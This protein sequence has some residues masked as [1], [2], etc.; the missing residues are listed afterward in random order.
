MTLNKSIKFI[1]A[2]AV[3]IGT[4]S[5]A[6]HAAAFKPAEVKL[7]DSG[8]RMI[9]TMDVKQGYNDNV[10]GTDD[11][12]VDSESSAVLEIDPSLSFVINRQDSTYN[13]DLNIETATFFDLDD[14][15]YVDWNLSAGINEV[16]N[17]RNRLN[18]GLEVGSYTEDKAA[19]N[20]GNAELDELSEYDGMN[21]DILYGFGAKSA[22][23]SFDLSLNYADKE[24]ANQF[25]DGNRD[26]EDLKFGAVGYVRVA[27]DTNALLEIRNSDLTYKNDPDAELEVLTALIGVTWEATAKTEGFVKVGQQQQKRAVDGETRDEPSWEVG[28]TWKPQTY[29]SLTFRT[30]QSFGLESQGG[31]Y[32]EYTK[33]G[34]DWMH[35]WTSAWS[36]TLDISYTDEELLKGNSFGDETVGDLLVTRELTEISLKTNYD[37]NR[38]SQLT[39][40]YTFSDRSAEEEER[41]VLVTD[42]YTRNYVFVGV[43]LSL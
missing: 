43:E 5:V 11:A 1:S 14:A 40:G 12:I 10:Y 28:V 20:V 32:T 41:I 21:A 24:Y 27:P 25:K 39:G 31:D 19:A 35:E 38:W 37:I 7:G 2:S 13:L 29:S 34:A 23:F 6:M 16:F 8:I 33:F 18:V 22:Q 9:P 17:S 26:T 3:I 36:T 15:D 4:S 30:E 42:V